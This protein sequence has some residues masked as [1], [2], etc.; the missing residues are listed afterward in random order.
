LLV[1]LENDS[2]KEHFNHRDG[3]VAEAMFWFK[4]LTELEMEIDIC[5]ARVEEEPVGFIIYGIDHKDNRHQK[6]ERGWLFSLGVDD[7]RD[8]RVEGEGDE[9]GRSW[10]GQHQRDQGDAA[11]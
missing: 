10:S 6:K 1:G 5:I 11:L 2:F 4:N 3:T 9:A 7:I 8:A